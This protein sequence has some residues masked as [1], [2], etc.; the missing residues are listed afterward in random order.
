MWVDE[1]PG[2][3]TVGVRN[4]GAFVLDPLPPDPLREHGRGLRM[5]S[6]MVDEMSL[7]RENG[8]IVVKLS[9]YR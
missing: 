4:G 9:V 5:M 3:V 1:R 8:L 6:K 7:L 2:A